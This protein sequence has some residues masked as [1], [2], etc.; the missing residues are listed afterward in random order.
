MLMVGLTGGIGAG[1]SAVSARLRELGAVIIDSDVL[2]REVVAA[3]TEGLAAVVD[4]FGAEVV[5]ADGELDRPALGA[6]VFGDEAARRRLEQIIHPRVRTRSAELTAAAAPDAIVVNDVPLLVEVGLAQTFHLVVVVEAD[7]ATRIARLVRTRGMAEE[8]ATARIAAQASDEV[9]RSAADVLL[10]NTGSLD[11]LL[12]KVDE[13]WRAR[14][15]PYESNLRNHRI[16]AADEGLVESQAEWPAQAA[17]LAARIRH[18]LRPVL[19]RDV[20]VAHIGPTAV[21]ELPARDEIELMLPVASPAEADKVN[22]ALAAAG[23]PPRPGAVRAYGSADPGRPA[24]LQV[25]VEGSAEWRSALLM[26]DFLR[27]V[28]PARARHA[29]AVVRE[30]WSDADVAAAEQWAAAT[31][32]TPA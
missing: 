29:T 31:G 18:A 13:L 12:A 5:G 6:K 1:K 19:G 27:T 11:E 17:R 15:R 23:L 21:P 20:P 24:G 9:R 16:A 10:D 3:G 25:R 30:P 32:W 7:A 14:L 28:A 26:R 22:D 2:A 8:Q 4:A